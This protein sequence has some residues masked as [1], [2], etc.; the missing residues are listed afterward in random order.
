MPIDPVTASLIASAI[1]S[2]IGGLQAKYGGMPTGEEKKLMGILTERFEEG[3]SPQEEA[4]FINTFAPGINR[5]RRAARRQIAFAAGQRGAQTATQAEQA[6]LDIPTAEQVIAPK[7]LEADIAVKSGAQSALTNLTQALSG[8]RQESIHA[9]LS[10]V[11]GGLGQAATS[12]LPDKNL[13]LEEILAMLFGGRML[14]NLDIPQYKPVEARYL[15]QR[16]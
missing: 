9:G 3:L 12:L 6:I 4:E 7:L 11:V 10:G 14:P 2:V 16:G 1:S 8:R 13:G 5:Q 15:E